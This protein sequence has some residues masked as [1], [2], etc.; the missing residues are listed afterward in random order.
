[1]PESE[2]SVVKE[3]PQKRANGGGMAFAEGAIARVNGRMTGTGELTDMQRLFVTSIVA[4]GGNATAAAE[5]AGYSTPRVDGWK[6]M[7]LPHVSTAV[8]EANE[9][10]LNADA[11]FAR[12]KM[13]W[14]MEHSEKDQVIFQ[15]CK[16]VLEASNLGLAAHA[17]KAGAMHSDKPLSEMTAGELDAFIAESDR[18]LKQMRAIEIVSE[19]SHLQPAVPIDTSK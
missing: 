2:T 14:L 6:L 4:N 19:T 17:I 16:W 1:M 5:E 12:H 13:R 10:A 15:A 8:N 7:Q 18:R 9:R 11:L 3:E